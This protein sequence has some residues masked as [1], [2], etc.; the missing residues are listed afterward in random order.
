MRLVHISSFFFLQVTC[1]A[2]GGWVTI[3]AKYNRH[4]VWKIRLLHA[5]LFLI[6]YYTIQIFD[7]SPNVRMSHAGR[8]RTAYSCSMYSSI[9]GV[10][11]ILLTHEHKFKSRVYY[12]NI[13]PMY[14]IIINI[15]C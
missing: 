10:L 7:N 6:D 8:E 4:P 14:I 5:L 1:A 13:V 9:H 2:V 12:N 11:N 3:T 15:Q